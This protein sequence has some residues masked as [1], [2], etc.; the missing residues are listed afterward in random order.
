MEETLA[1]AIRVDDNL[2]KAW[3]KHPNLH[4]IESEEFVKDKIDKVLLGIA[5]ELGILESVK[6]MIL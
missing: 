5:H 2:I 3:E 4:I 6:D 1:E